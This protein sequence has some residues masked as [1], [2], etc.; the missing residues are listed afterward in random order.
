MALELPADYSDIELRVGAQKIQ[1]IDEVLLLGGSKVEPKERL[2]RCSLHRRAKNDSVARVGDREVLGRCA[3]IQDV[4]LDIALLE[5][6][7]ERADADQFE[8]R[9]EGLVDL[10]LVCRIDEGIDIDRHA[11]SNVKR[12]G[13]RPANDVAHVVRA[14]NRHQ[15]G[16]HRLH[17]GAMRFDQEFERVHSLLSAHRP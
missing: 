10:V 11:W 16:E 6:R 4:D 14:Q 17:R 2:R 13:T 5:L 7:M 12:K 1:G 15:L 8:L 9:D 3:G